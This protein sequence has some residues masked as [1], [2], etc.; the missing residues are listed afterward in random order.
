[1][2]KNALRNSTHVPQRG[3]SDYYVHDAGRVI[4]YNDG[5]PTQYL[6]VEVTNKASMTA[7]QEFHG[8]PISSADYNAY[9][10]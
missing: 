7:P 10:K 5:K 9:L 4:G 2:E 1:M 8:H 3:G 6:R